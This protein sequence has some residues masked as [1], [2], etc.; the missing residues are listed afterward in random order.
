MEN[1][2]II[3]KDPFVGY[4][5]DDIR[6]WLTKH[7]RE[8]D[9][10]C[11]MMIVHNKVGMLSHLCDEGYDPWVKYSYEEWYEIETDLVERIRGILSVENKTNGTNY[12]LDGIGT[13]YMIKPFMERNGYR[14]GAGWWIKTGCEI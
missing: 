7:N 3:D 8:D 9:I 10:A 1:Y 13:Y 12:T 4:T 11:V 6:N 5:P 2:L 14:D